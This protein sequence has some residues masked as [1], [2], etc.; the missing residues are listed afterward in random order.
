MAQP[1]ND[2][3]ADSA[4]AGQ[5][6]L[7]RMASVDHYNR[8]IYRLIRPYIGRRVAEVGCGIG[9][10]TGYF[11]HAD[12]LLA[13]DLLPESAA[14]VGE[15]FQA[16]PQ[17]LV[18]QGDVCD[19]AFVCWAATHRFDTV[20]STNMLEHVEDDALALAHM[21]RLL[22]PG[23][24]L[25]LFVPAGSYLFGSLDEA[26]GHYRRYDRRGLATRVRAAGFH[27]RKI[28][29]VNML[30]VAGW[31]VN[32]RLLRRRLLPTDQLRLFN[33]IAPGLQ[34]LEGA[35]SPPFGQ[36]LLCVARRAEG[37]V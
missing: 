12:L 37:R 35:I 2:R 27:I 8:W 24:H 36:S 18:R 17:V 13:F 7:R 31:F 9:N 3:N 20:I 30:G 19:P 6:T 21:R 10:M 26:V 33:W 15:K 1:L 29:Y 23:G 14:W 25:L 16:Y 22:V 4:G 32:S 34:A 28:H 11:L 5:E